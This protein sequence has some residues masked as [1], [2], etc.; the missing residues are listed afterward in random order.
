M[1]IQGAAGN[2]KVTPS[3]TNQ[4]AAMISHGQRD[5]TPLHMDQ[6]NQ[7]PG[8]FNVKGA[9]VKAVDSVYSRYYGSSMKC[10]QMLQKGSLHR[11]L[12]IRHFRLYLSNLGLSVSNA[13]CLQSFQ[14]FNPDYT[15]HT[16]INHVFFVLKQRSPRMT[17]PFEFTGDSSLQCNTVIT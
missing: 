1:Y 15:L 5:L 3:L 9:T 17:P 16:A 6:L 7:I 12:T 8:W 14:S 2:V 10:C 11:Q 13:G 4:F